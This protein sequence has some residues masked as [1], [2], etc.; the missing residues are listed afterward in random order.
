MHFMKA[1]ETA[2]GI[3]TAR[4]QELDRSFP[5]AALRQHVQG[6]LV[7]W[8]HITLT[9]SLLPGLLMGLDTNEHCIWQK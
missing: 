4:M 8:L 2:A 7:M 9:S 6:L 5:G 3:L 1:Q